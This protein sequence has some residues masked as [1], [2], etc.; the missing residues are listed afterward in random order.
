MRGPRLTTAR[1]IR[2][3]LAF[4]IGIGV[5][6]FG[7][8]IART[9]PQLGFTPR[10]PGMDEP[11]RPGDQTRRF[12]PD[13]LPL[14]RPSPGTDMP[15]TSDMPNRLQF[16][17]AADDPT[18]LDVTGAIAEGD[19]VRFE[20]FLETTSLSPDTIRLNSP[21]GSV[22]DA[23]AIGRA[24]RDAGFDTTVGE[25]GICLSA[26]PY[27]LAA[28]VERSAAE[29]AQVGV[30]QHYFDESTVLPAFLAVEDIQR[31]QGE[32]LGYLID[33]G[34]D[35]ALMQHALVTPPQEIYILLRE[36]LEEYAMVTDVE[37]TG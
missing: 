18:V 17:E 7:Q 4:Q 8:D 34:I 11:I 1:A 33:M 2:A 13:R 16:T 23:L 14:R 3:L 37:E 27:L 22:I 10:S 28:G 26:C 31:G 6:L 5:V 21:G 35:P 29:T 32:V 36:E 30:H 25:D 15:D 20:D 12:Q 9:L 24:I 19:F